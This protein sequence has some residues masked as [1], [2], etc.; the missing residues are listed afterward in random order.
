MKKKI[1]K[2]FLCVLA[3]TALWGCKK[4]EGKD[5]QNQTEGTVSETL[6]YEG[7]RSA[8][9]TVSYDEVI[10]ELAD[11]KNV[12]VTITGDYEVTEELVESTILSLLSYYGK[13]HVEV[14]DHTVVEAGD[15][16]MI[17]YTG[18]KDGVAFDNGAA[19]D[20]LMDP[21]NNM[22]VSTQGYYIE[23]FCD[24]LIGAA[25]GD[26]LKTNVTFPE[27]YHSAD[28]AGQPAVFEIKV[29]GIYRPATLSDI[30]DETVEELFA[31][32]GITTTADLTAYVKETLTAK[33]ENSKAQDTQSAVQEYMLLHSKVE[34]PEEYM[35]ARLAEVEY[36]TAMDNCKDGQTLE[37]FL[38]TQGTDLETERAAW[39]L[40]LSKQIKTEFIFG[41][42]ADL[43]NIEVD[44]SELSQYVDY[45]VQS[46]NGKFSTAE[47]VYNYYGVGI[48]EDGKKALSQ[49]YRV[50]KAL[51][52]VSDQ[53][54][55]TVE[56]KEQEEE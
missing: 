32:R 36:S 49:L 26:E 44:E 25:V 38:E 2:L 10:K 29:K 43:E 46:E 5:T 28:L 9:L 30:A 40:T 8:S 11:Y 47:D 56:A 12:P 45:I 51:S 3:C 50:T 24:D 19:Q 17:D 16:V 41:K 13:A 21:V 18:Y 54:Q 1:I 39:E 7:V 4:D 35:K 6:T 42:I 33:A 15:Y 34:I 27:Q 52:F 14:T 48:T 55:V 37:E 20:V 23:G 22:D 31:E 53:A